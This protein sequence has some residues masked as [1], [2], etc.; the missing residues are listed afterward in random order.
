MSINYKIKLYYCI[1]GGPYHCH[2]SRPHAASH[3]HWNY[4]PALLIMVSFLSS[5]HPCCCCCCCCSHPEG[6]WQV[7]IGVWYKNLKD[8]EVQ[9]LS[10]VHT[11]FGQVCLPAARWP[12]GWM[13]NGV[14]NCQI[15][16]N[17]VN[18]KFEMVR[19][20]KHGALFVHMHIPVG[21][22]RWTYQHQSMNPLMLPV[23]HSEDHCAMD[24]YQY[25]QIS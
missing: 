5:S 24:W 20:W 25:M 22:L 8:G 1:I 3:Q 9:S 17:N 19:N 23:V 10:V 12:D 15:F 16:W 6:L 14:S 7:V 4:A 11:L 18:W 21:L 2:H 13:D